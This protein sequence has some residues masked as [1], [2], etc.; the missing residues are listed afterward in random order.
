MFMGIVRVKEWEP[1]GEAKTYRKA[2]LNEC[3]RG[4]GILL[5]HAEQQ[6]PRS[7]NK[8]M[9]GS[10]GLNFGLSIAPSNPCDAALSVSMFSPGDLS[11]VRVIKNVLHRKLPCFRG[12][13]LLQLNR[14]LSWEGSYRSSCSTPESVR[15][16]FG[17]VSCIPS[18]ASLHPLLCPLSSP[19]GLFFS[20]S[21]RCAVPHV[22]PIAP[23]PLECQSEVME[24]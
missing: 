20:L 21:D 23:S 11:K 14:R 9:I 22:I 7:A 3:Q 2:E 15:S 24:N 10:S 13:Q 5:T 17:V 19:Q 8:L 1:A 4:E 16:D 18:P 6:R 12:S